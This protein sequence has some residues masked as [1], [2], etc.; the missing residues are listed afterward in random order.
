MVGGLTGCAS[1]TGF[2]VIR[3]GIR[4]FRRV[5]QIDGARSGVEFCDRGLD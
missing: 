5:S 2:R 1:G 3:R 4:I